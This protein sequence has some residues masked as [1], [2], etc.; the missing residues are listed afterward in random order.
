MFFAH[1]TAQ[2]APKRA[3]I[4]YTAMMQILLSNDESPPIYPELF[5]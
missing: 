2:K 3:W 5:D 1:T 4:A